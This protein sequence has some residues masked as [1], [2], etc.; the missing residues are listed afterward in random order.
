M[1]YE[2][3]FESKNMKRLTTEHMPVAFDERVQDEKQN[4]PTG[5]IITICGEEN[6]ASLLN[7]WNR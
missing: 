3:R 2:I 1:A 7:T 4:I 5:H 6:V